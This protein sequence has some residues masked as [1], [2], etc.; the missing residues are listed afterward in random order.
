MAAMML[1][2]AVPPVAAVARASSVRDRG[3]TSSALVASLY[4]LVWGAFGGAVYTVR[5]VFG[6]A[7]PLVSWRHS[8]SVLAGVA[9]AAVARFRH[10][11]I[12]QAL[13]P[14]LPA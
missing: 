8:P 3:P 6:A 9:I 4:I 5:E 2:S 1:P 10:M 13:Q 14:W 7:G 12:C 11:N